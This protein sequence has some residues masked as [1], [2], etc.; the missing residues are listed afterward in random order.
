MSQALSDARRF[1]AER[2]AVI[3][4]EAKPGFHLAPRTGWM[5][6]PNGLSWYKGQYHLFYQ[7]H[8]YD[9]HWGPMHWGHA[10]SGD[11]LHWRPMPAALAPDM[12]YDRDG[13]FSGSALTL[14]DGRQL[15]MYTGVLRQTL[16]DGQLK[17]TQTQNLAFG[18]GRNY[19]KY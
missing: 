16:P 1:E 9:S 13:C 11:L 4:P 7:Y 8:P 10:V 19:M 12:P 2:E 6:D 15:L 17:E 18:D 3:P 14:P 5:N